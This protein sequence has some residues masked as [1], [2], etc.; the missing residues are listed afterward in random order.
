MFYDAVVGRLLKDNFP[1]AEEAWCSGE[2]G[3]MC[4][5]HLTL[6]ENAIKIKPDFWT[7]GIDYRTCPRR[8]CGSVREWMK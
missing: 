6:R 8:H 2:V 7:D 4:C 1:D 5:S 3:L